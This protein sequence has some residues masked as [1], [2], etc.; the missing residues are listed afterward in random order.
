M[1]FAKIGQSAATC[2]FGDAFPPSFSVDL[3]F[4]SNQQ[5]EMVQCVTI[6][7]T[8]SHLVPQEWETS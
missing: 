3:L 2:M 7:F 4:R 5:E 6:A 1:N 8:I